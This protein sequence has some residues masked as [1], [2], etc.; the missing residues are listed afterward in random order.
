MRA[1]L[2]DMQVRPRLG[3]K[4]EEYPSSN[5]TAIAT[6]TRL[7]R[8][9]N[10]RIRRLLIVACFLLAATPAFGEDEPEWN[11]I[12]VR[13]TIDPDGRLHV[14]EQ[15]QVDVPPNVQRLERTYWNDS[16]QEVT[17]DAITL[18]DGDRTIPLID[19]G[20]LDH[21]HRWRQQLWPGRAAWSVR[22]KTETPSGWRSL[23]YVIES[24]VS[25][26]VIPAWSI[27]RG[28]VSHDTSGGLTDPR[29]R[30]REV[31]PI[32]REALK[33]P[34]HRFLL[35]Y[36]Y[37]M[38]PPSTKGT[39]IQ[40]QI[41]WPAGWNPVHEITPDT[42]ARPIKRDFSNPDQYRVTHLFEEDGRHLLTSVYTPRHAIRMAA[43][44]GFPIVG[45]LFW[46][47]FVLREVFRRP[48][49]VDDGEQLLRE[50]VYNEAPEVVEARWSGRVGF[51][52]VEGF[53]RRLEREHK[54]A[55]TIEPHRVSIRLLVPREQLSDYDK[56]G[57]SVYLPDGVWETTSDE[58]RQRRKGAEFDLDDLLRVLLQAIANTTKKNEGAP[59]YSKL[60]SFAIFITGIYFCFQE[61]V[62]MGREPVIVAAALIFSSMLFSIW[63]AS[64][65][66][67][68][69]R[70]SLSKVLWLLLPLAITTLAVITIH[71]TGEVPPTYFGSAGFSV[72]ML[73]L[74][75]AILASSATRGDSRLARARNWLRNQLTSAT[76]HL[77]PDALPWLHALD[78]QR[79]VAKSNWAGKHPQAFADDDVEESDDDDEYWPDLL[80]AHE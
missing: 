46:I 28:K 4:R 64:L 18:Y 11:S 60:T 2:E 25:D 63:P 8:V 49:G 5:V 80:S 24:H 76:P 34:K 65:C 57:L 62:R 59:W 38:P 66:R 78:L 30:L 37:D 58:V 61:V 17:F 48:R 71:F 77:R 42:V 26:T 43:L 20:D 16:E 74:Y 3:V 22:D 79:E 47:M 41:Y 50:V 70:N 35:D 75:K 6:R 10:K 55:L 45:L 31:I 33:N 52:T 14:S 1:F 19:S 51:P 27:P 67:Y 69:I 29:K 39:Q 53:L 15:A 68:A 12:I 36:L 9:D 72:A 7:K 54:I 40:L 13:F 21:A 44:V 23:T 56:A 73:G 32:W